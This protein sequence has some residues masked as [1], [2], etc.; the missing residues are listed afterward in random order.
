MIY[1]DFVKKET[2]DVQDILA[3]ITHFV[4]PKN[5]IDTRFEDVIN[6]KVVDLFEGKLFV[7][8]PIAKLGKVCIL[9]DRCRTYEDSDYATGS[10][11]IKG[12]TYNFSIQPGNILYIGVGR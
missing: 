11:K 9:D 1:Y 6:C 12:R 3:N 4:E 5:T 7:A 8:K 2:I 10:M